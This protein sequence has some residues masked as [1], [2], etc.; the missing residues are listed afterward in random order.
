VSK[1][2]AKSFEELGAKLGNPRADWSAIS[3]DGKI[4]VISIWGDELDYSDRTRPI[5]DCRNHKDISEWSAFPGNKLRKHHIE[6]ALNHCDGLFKVVLLRAKDPNALPREIKEAW[7]WPKMMG[8]ITDF[9]P[10][11]GAFRAE[12]SRE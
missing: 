9:D 6:Y 10:K 2:F 12:F 3:S 8:N 11:T 4:V 1:N 5:L 7:V